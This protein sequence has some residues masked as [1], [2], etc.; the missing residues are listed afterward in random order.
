M[1]NP[2]HAGLGTHIKDMNICGDISIW[3]NELG[4]RS[5]CQHVAD[6]TTHRESQQPSPSINHTKPL[7]V[8]SKYL[9]VELF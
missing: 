9:V 2:K 8:E 3:R 5:A 1:E 4:A 7:T 6:Y